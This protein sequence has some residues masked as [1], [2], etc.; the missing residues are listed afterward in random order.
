MSSTN[1]YRNAS[2]SVHKA[3]TLIELLVVIAII[4]ILAAILFPVFGRA[5]ENAK[6]SACLSNIRQ[7][8]MAFMQYVQ[9]NDERFPFNKTNATTGQ[10]SWLYAAE[11]YLKSTAVLRCPADES[12]NF[13]VPIDGKT[14]DWGGVRPTSYTMNLFFVPNATSTATKPFSNLSATQKPANVILLAESATNWTAAYFHA[15]VWPTGHWDTTKNL[16]DDLDLNRHFD[17][18]NVCYLDGHAKWTTWSKAWWQDT[19]ANPQVLKGSFDP[20]QS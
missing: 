14:G 13:D 10:K 16:P 9:D 8:G 11:P 19:T 17:G 20:N 4:A 3:F 7:L 12:V 1:E 6:R 18:F 5:R 15:S 2:R